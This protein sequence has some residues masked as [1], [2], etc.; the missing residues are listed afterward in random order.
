V[1]GAD[2]EMN[3]IRSIY[4]SVQGAG[5]IHED[6]DFPGYEP[7]DT[8]ITVSEIPSTAIFKVRKLVRSQLTRLNN[9]QPQYTGPCWE[10]DQQWSVD[11]RIIL[12]L[13]SPPLPL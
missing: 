10:F 13:S 12:S 11:L 3:V 2:Y 8:P 5:D 9:C 1:N 7:V 6:R 4:T